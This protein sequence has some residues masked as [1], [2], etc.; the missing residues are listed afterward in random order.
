MTGQKVLTENQLRQIP[1]AAIFAALGI[2]L[3]QFFHVLGLGSAFL[4]MFI[5]VVLGSMLM[6]WQFALAVA[7][8]SPLVSFFLTGM[9]PIVPPVLPVMIVE[10]MVMALSASLLRTHGNKAVWLALT[11]AIVAERLVLFSASWLILPMLGYTHIAFSL[12]LL[13]KG[14]PGIILLYITVPLAMAYIKR[15]FPQYYNLGR[16]E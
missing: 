15:G 8:I 2:I 12:A 7:V 11:V 4:P 14:F 6:T 3:P 5:P 9:P 16:T 1:L 10:L 13:L